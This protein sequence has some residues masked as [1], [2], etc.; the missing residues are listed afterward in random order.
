MCASIFWNLFICSL[1]WF[2]FLKQALTAPFGYKSKCNTITRK[3]TCPGVIVNSQYQLIFPRSLHKQLLL[4]QRLGPLLSG[5]LDWEKTT[6]ESEVTSRGSFF[7]KD[8]WSPSPV[9]AWV[10]NL[11][12]LQANKG[13]TLSEGIWWSYL[14][15][16]SPSSPVT[17]AFC[18]EH[19]AELPLVQDRGS[20]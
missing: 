11:L 1:S 4:W 13:G 16:L 6:R 17:L 19:G 8:N 14:N 18:P 9:T 10:K 7:P 15:C 3:I 5:V 12:Q 20:V 2:L